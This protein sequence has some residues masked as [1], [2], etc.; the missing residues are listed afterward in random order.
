MRKSLLLAL[1]LLLAAWP[2]GC[3]LSPG[4]GELARAEQ[5]WR[6]QQVS[7]Y[8]IEVLEVLSVW[9]A[10]YHLITVRDGEVADSEARCLPAPAEGGKCK[11][12][13]FD[14]RDFT[15]PGL[16]AKAR[17]ALS[18]PTRRYVKVEYDTEWG[19]PRVI[20]FRNPEVVDGDWLWRV[21]MFE[22]GQ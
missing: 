8:R 10:Q 19:F 5:R 7:D 6:A 4:G 9:H 3:V 16:F 13:D 21:T 14:A 1:S 18:A 15:V 17:E 20:S 22:A 2:V 11:V 12:Y